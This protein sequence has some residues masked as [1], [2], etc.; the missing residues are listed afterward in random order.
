MS[1]WMF[2]WLMQGKS[3]EEIVEGSQSPKPSAEAVRES[4]ICEKQKFEDAALKSVMR[5]AK[6]GD[7][8]AIDWLAQRGLFESIKNP[9]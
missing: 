8:N 1:E 4:I 2:R 5:N 3:I 9:E 6:N 7:V